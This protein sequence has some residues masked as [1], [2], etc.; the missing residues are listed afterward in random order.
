MAEWRRVERPGYFGRRRQER[1]QAYDGLYG[2]SNWRLAWQIGERMGGFDEVVMLYED[3][4]VL[5]LAQRT[6]LLDQLVRDARDVY[7]DAPSNVESGLDYARQETARTHIQDIAL[8]RSLVRL[9]R[10]FAGKQLIQI[11]GRGAEPPV[12]PLSMALCPY[13]VPFH[14]SEWIVRPVLDGWWLED[15]GE[16]S[17][18]AFYQSNKFLEV[19]I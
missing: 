11:R 18:E 7:D 15:G 2:P 12:H 6:D 9:G 13:Q 16:G 8:R 1:H 17:V 10:R 19:R 5:Y 4:Y 3:A 14:R